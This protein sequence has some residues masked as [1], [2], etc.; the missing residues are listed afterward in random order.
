MCIKGR[1]ELHTCLLIHGNHP[2][3]LVESGS[4]LASIVHGSDLPLGRPAVAFGNWEL[5][6]KV[7]IPTHFFLHRSTVTTFH[8]SAMLVC[9]WIYRWICMN[10]LLLRHFS[11]ICTTKLPTFESPSSSIISLAGEFIIPKFI[12]TL[13]LS[14][15]SRELLS[16]SYL[17]HISLHQSLTYL[18]LDTFASQRGLESREQYPCEALHSLV[19]ILPC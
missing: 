17:S 6:Y 7:I 3:R 16:N 1:R 11:C 8:D 15:R 18:L 5:P 19:S 13:T 12:Q 10:D 2:I 9:W 4:N 14:S